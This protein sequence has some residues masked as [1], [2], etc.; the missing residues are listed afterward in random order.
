MKRRLLISTIVA[1]GLT[2]TTFTEEGTTA[3][4]Y[5]SGRMPELPVLVVGGG[6]V[7]L[8]VSVS[9][10]GS[11]LAVTPLRETAP[12]TGILAGVVKSW[13]FDPAQETAPA[14]G[15][16]RPSRLAVDSRMLVAGV[17]RAPVVLG[18]TRGEA[19]K[20]GAAPSG[21]IPFPLNLDAPPFPPT[22][23]D[24]GV[25]MLEGELNR[26]GRLVATTPVVSMVPFDDAA[27]DAMKTWQFRPGRL[28]V[29]P[30]ATYVY[31]VFGFPTPI[32]IGPAPK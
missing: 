19:I 25:I 12:F 13:R 16:E 26:D 10:D 31:A 29:M 30:A 17:F 22:A 15:G 20:E 9:R 8:E 4:R 7:L 5:R 24:G 6:E 21:Q 14:Q 32:G 27:R 23:R 28:P 1:L 2:A 18:P 3:A 11:V